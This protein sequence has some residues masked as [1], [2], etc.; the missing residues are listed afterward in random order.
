MIQSIFKIHSYTQ[1]WNVTAFQKYNLIYK[2]E[3]VVQKDDQ[4]I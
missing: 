4:L 3:I 2:H 1:R